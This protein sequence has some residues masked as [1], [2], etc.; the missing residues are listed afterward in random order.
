[1][2]GV[3]QNG[4]HAAAALTVLLAV[5]LLIA[6]SGFVGVGVLQAKWLER[7]ALAAQLDALKRRSLAA[8]APQAP[9]PKISVKP[10]LAEENFA[11]AANAL[12]KRVVG[13][14]EQTNGKLISVAVDPPIA[15]DADLAR[16]VSV[17]VT[18]EL[19]N[20]AL[21]KVLYE[22]ES[23]VPF[24]FVDSF[25]ASRPEAAKSG[26]QGAPLLSVSLNVIGYR[27]KGS[28]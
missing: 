5:L 25:T 9:E 22:L 14:I 3:R 16:R 7:D 15:G 18:A 8:S 19:T 10:F 1:M 4:S 2:S 11:L 21:Q 26:A 12:Q 24:A 13:L 23:A 17:Q 6:G 20:N 27:H 28:P